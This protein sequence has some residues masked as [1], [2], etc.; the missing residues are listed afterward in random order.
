M[1]GA[2][3]ATWR[4]LRA[5]GLARGHPPPE[6]R[7]QGGGEEAIRARKRATTIGKQKSTAARKRCRLTQAALFLIRATGEGGSTPTEP[8]YLGIGTSW[9][10]AIGDSADAAHT[11]ASAN[12]TTILPRQR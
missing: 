8:G 3:A 10:P 11:T 6:G 5:F 4:A 1:D 12:T 2:R 7:G 9:E